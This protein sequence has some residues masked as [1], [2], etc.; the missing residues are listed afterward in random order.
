MT[1]SP[2]GW[3]AV[4]LNEKGLPGKRKHVEAWSPDGDPLVV[5]YTVG[6]L[7]NAR[8]IV[9]FDRLELAPDPFVAAIPANGWRLHWEA[10]GR[11]G[12]NDLI[13]FAIRADGEAVPIRSVDGDHGD[14]FYACDNEAVQLLAPGE[15]PAE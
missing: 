11:S 7:V 14:A 1:P 3:T 15:E 10:D 12:V 8:S 4:Y 2:T 13:G 5:D 9:G 6:A